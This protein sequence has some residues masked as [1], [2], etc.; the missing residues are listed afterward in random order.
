MS[1]KR[2][3]T[4]RYIFS[5]IPPVNIK[6]IL[7]KMFENNLRFL[8]LQNSAENRY[9]LNNIDFYRSIHMLFVVQLV[10][11]QL[12]FGYIDL[13]MIIDMSMMY[14]AH[15]IEEQYSHVFHLIGERF[16]PQGSILN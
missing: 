4:T 12:V 16:S 9:I 7:P 1:A 3:P 11:I 5:H 15:L 13:M 14:P 10:L 6:L 2:V 8:F